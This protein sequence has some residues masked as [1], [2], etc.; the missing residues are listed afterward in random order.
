[1][2]HAF[3]GN[4]SGYRAGI[5]TEILPEKIVPSR[6]AGPRRWRLNRANDSSVL[7]YIPV[8]VLPGYRN[9]V[10]RPFEV[11]SGDCQSFPGGRGYPFFSKGFRRGISYHFAPEILLRAHGLKPDILLWYNQERRHPGIPNNKKRAGRLP[12][13]VGQS[14]VPERCVDLLP[15]LIYPFLV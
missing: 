10:P 2:S 4:T 15:E 1:M 14:F 5:V 12:G 8:Q 6:C 9:R 13:Q 7:P 11:K 3:M